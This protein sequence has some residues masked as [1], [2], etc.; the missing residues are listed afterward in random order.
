MFYI[1]FAAGELQFWV[2]PG[3]EECQFILNKSASLPNSID[4]LTDSVRAEIKAE[5]S[6]KE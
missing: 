4:H 2:E 5:T 6:T 3:A 1:L